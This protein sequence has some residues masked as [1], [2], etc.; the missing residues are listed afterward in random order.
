MDD[1]VIPG[2]SYYVYDCWPKITDSVH[3]QTPLGIRGFSQE[4]TYYAS[5]GDKICT[6]KHENRVDLVALKLDP[7]A[8]KPKLASYKRVWWPSYEIT[9]N[10]YKERPGYYLYCHDKNG[11]RA[12][13]FPLSSPDED[14]QKFTKVDLS[15]AVEEPSDFTKLPKGD[16][17]LYKEVKEQQC[18]L[19]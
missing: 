6:L 2:A 12:F 11:N 5:Q 16:F 7:Q 14:V 17:T 8:E 4:V 3:K 10:V 1:S 15:Q 18:I 13:S 19:C 9:P